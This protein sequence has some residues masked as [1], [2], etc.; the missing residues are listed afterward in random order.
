MGDMGEI[1]KAM[2]EDSK[3]RRANNRD[4]APKALE[5]ACISF[6]SKN[7][8]AHLIVSHKNVVVDYWP[9]T[10]KWIARKGKKGRGIKNLINYLR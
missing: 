4:S 9:G 2:K 8:G 5:G 7:Y 6:E 1:Y 10:G 3:S